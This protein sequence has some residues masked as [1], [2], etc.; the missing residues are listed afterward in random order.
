MNSQIK[1]VNNL[2][3]SEGYKII[4]EIC[5]KKLELSHEEILY[6]LNL[7]EKELVATFLSEYSLFGQ[8]SLSL[9]EKFINSNLDDSNLDFVSDLIYFANDFGLDLNYHK[10]LEFTLIDDEDVDFIVLACLQYLHSNIKLLYVETIIKNLEYIRDNTQYHQN[11]QLL[12]SLI[13]FRVTHKIEYLDFVTEL[14]NFDNS[15]L[16]FLKNTLKDKSYNSAYFKI[17]NALN[18]D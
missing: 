13:L 1:A 5:E 8:E 7:K 11:E 15:N 17:P 10:I 4:K 9:I 6:I 16:E 14:I 3:F 18:V 12:A 2:P